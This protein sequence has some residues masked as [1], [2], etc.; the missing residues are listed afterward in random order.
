MRSS[1]IKGAAREAPRGVTARAPD[2][3]QTDQSRERLVESALRAAREQAALAAEAAG[4]AKGWAA[5]RIEAAVERGLLAAAPTVEAAAGRMAPA[6]D[7]A[8]DRIVEDLLP[9][10]VEA[11]HAASAASSAARVAAAESVSRSVE[12]AARSVGDA[13]R[14]VAEA[15]PTARRRRH[16]RRRRTGL[17]LIAAATA[18]VAA[19]VAS[20]AR[21]RSRQPVWEVTPTSPAEGQGRASG[22]PELSVVAS[23]TSGDVDA[24]PAAD[25]V[26]VTSSAGDPTEE[27]LVGDDTAA[28]PEIDTEAESGTPAVEAPVTEAEV[29]AQGD[30]LTDQTPEPHRAGRRS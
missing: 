2:Q 27:V 4:H 23:A 10:L 24:A 18:A 17:L 7:A 13:A 29:L 21:G 25:V 12:D 3:T 26:P 19:A 15:T 22:T 16:R 6:V 5:P 11:V 30:A 9:R 8:R 14:S 20:L 1:S 28:T